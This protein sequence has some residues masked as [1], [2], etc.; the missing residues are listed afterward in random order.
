MARPINEIANDVR[1]D[2]K[3]VNYAAKPYLEAMF[4]LRNVSDSYGQDSAASIV[5]YFLSNAR[6]WRGPVAK[7]IKAE[8][9]GMIKGKWGSLGV[10]N[11]GS[12]P[13][14]ARS[15]RLTFHEDPGHGWL[16]V[17]MALLTELGIA[18]EI[19]SYSYMKGNMAFLEEDMDAS[20]LL[21]AAK[22]AG[23]RITT[24]EDYTDYDSPIRRYRT[25]RMA[26]S[27]L[28]SKLIRLAH[29]NPEMRAHLLPLLK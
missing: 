12:M 25:F 23:I 1:Q 4:D 29:G 10:L 6:S 11:Q 17:P 9:Q 2:W 19:S 27:N 18:D 16:E 5:R 28:R 22:A 26:S 8:L 3:S 13:K 15:L 20:T 14:T 21:R 7:A 24:E